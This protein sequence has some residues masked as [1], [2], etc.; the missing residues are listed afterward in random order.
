MAVTFENMQEAN[1][2]YG[3]LRDAVASHKG[4]DLDP[5]SNA[6]EV[7]A[8]DAEYLQSF[9]DSLAEGFFGRFRD[10]LNEA[11]KQQQEQAVKPTI[12]SGEGLNP[13]QFSGG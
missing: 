13:M 11:I 8:R 12:V 3:L 6:A 2:Y 5:V 7:G 1:L 10:T 9:V 4:S